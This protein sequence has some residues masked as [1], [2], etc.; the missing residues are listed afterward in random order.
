MADEKRNPDKYAAVEFDWKERPEAV[1]E[2]VN[3]ALVQRAI[4]AEARTAPMAGR[5]WCF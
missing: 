2:Q 1:I 5:W 3:A 4:A